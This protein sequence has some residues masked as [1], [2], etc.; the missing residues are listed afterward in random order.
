MNDDTSPRSP[1]ESPADDA[2][3][4]AVV[5]GACFGGLGAALTLAERG[6]RVLVL[7]AMTYP[8]G[9]A[10]TFAKDG[11]RFESGATLF[12]GFGEGQLFR[13]WIDRHALPVRFRRLEP[14]IE[15]R[16]PDLR[17]PLLANRADM[18]AHLV[19]LPGAPEA[20]IRR[21][22]A[23][24]GRVA[25]AL[26]PALD[27]PALLPNFGR[28]AIARHLRALP[29][30]LRIAPLLGRTLADVMRAEGV[31]GFIRAMGLTDVCLVGQSYGG[32][33]VWR[34][35]ADHPGLVGRVVLIDSSGYARPGDGWMPEEV[36]IRNHPLARW[37][38]LLNSPDRL[39]TALV[40]Q[41]KRAVTD[42]EVE[43]FFHVCDNADDWLAMMQLARDEN[44]T[45]EADI[46]TIAQ[47]TLL[48]W[49]ADDITY[50]P[51]V[52]ARRFAADI[53]RSELRIVENSGH[54]V[55]EEQPAEVVRL[56]GEFANR[57]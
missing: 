54:Y 30:Y 43:E 57:P 51:S 21:F 12:A 27:D 4:D 40:P 9:C 17:L 49:G 18:V 23:L 25:D 7:E 6:A 2:R 47:P 37:G 52:Y 42:E 38:Y 33:F 20:A 48:V 24:Q 22:F 44:G 39:R 1:H 3:Y 35:A 45:R 16:A 36:E 31:A 15:L 11:Y 14:A 19:A 26:W 41:Y 34:A 46:R 56:V 28:G 32:E 10:S 55:Q 29:S 53:A 50:K 5:V 13:R 8:G